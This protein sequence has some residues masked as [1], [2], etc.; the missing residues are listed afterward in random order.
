MGFR[1]IE[2]LVTSGS[3][4]LQSL[5]STN[6]GVLSFANVTKRAVTPPLPLR[7]KITT[8]QEW[9]ALEV[10][11]SSLYWGVHFEH[12]FSLTQKNDSNLFNKSLNSF[13]KYF[14]N[15]AK[16]AANFATGSNTG[17]PD[18]AAFGVIDADRFCNNLFTL[19][20]IQV[21][22]G[23]NGLADT[24][25]WN[26]AVYCRDGKVGS[27]D[28]GNLGADSSKVRG[29]TVSDIPDNSKFAK[30][31]FVVQGGNNGVNIFDE[32][33]FEI[34]NN[35]VAA[36]MVVSNARAAKP[37]EGPNVRTY[38]KALDLMRNTVNMDIQLLAIPG[39]REPVV[40][41]AAT[42]AVEDRFDALY[43]MDIEQVDENGD[44]VKTSAQ[45]PSVTNTLTE[46][47]NRSVDSSFAAAYFPDVLYKDPT[48]VNL[49]VPPSVVVLGAL[50]LNDR[51]GQPWFAPA[52]FTRG[53]LPQAVLEPRVSLYRSEMDKLYDASINPIVAFS[54]SQKNN[55]TP[56]GGV[57]VWGQKTLQ[58]A[59]S[60]LDRINVRRL[61]IDIRR[62]VKDIA[63]SIIFEPNREATL[64]AFSAAVTPRLQR[65]QDLAGLE[66]FRV[67]IDSSTTTE[68]DVMN[69]TIRGKIFVQPTK[70]IEFVS[71]DFVVA[72]NI[73][74]QA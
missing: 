36:D 33:E 15:F 16:S 56:N 66:R 34:N 49:H 22:T 24:N 62:Q 19:E 58:V 35:A 45:I 51:L 23:S 61:L 28:T 26:K 38:L 55:L 44:V 50:S 17:Q 65:I 27:T 13:V 68:D 67:I 72:N 46:F 60:A 6:N 39:I 69:N 1:G 8:G 41:D 70:S 9:T 52:G 47:T 73:Q 2:H 37:E 30:F 71:L 63:Q 25:K 54:N 21:V 42:L 40:T 18:T 10:A 57:V 32:D 20:N 3:A 53:A 7:R 5:G 31:S 59:A 43:I 11:E 29:F 64:A 14:P 12:P 4:P 74:G 48:G